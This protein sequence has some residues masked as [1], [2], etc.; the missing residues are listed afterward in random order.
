MGISQPSEANRDS[1]IAR[2][3]PE[4]P[5]KIRQ[6]LQGMKHDN[7]SGYLPE[8]ANLELQVRRAAFWVR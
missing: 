7:P 3:T 6:Q 8:K 4:L 2:L 1:I 5:N